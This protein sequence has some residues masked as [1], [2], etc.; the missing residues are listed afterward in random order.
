M[1]NLEDIIHLYSLNL[2]SQ[3]III[4]EKE[5]TNEPNH[6]GGLHQSREKSRQGIVA[7]KFNRI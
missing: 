6:D 1:H 7:A 4:H 3:K 2:L 5:K